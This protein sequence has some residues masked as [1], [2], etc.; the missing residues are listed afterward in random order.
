[1]STYCIYRMS[2]LTGQKDR[3]FRG[4]R[5]NGRPIFA[6]DSE[7]N[8]YQLPTMKFRNRQEA[9]RFVEAIRVNHNL[10]QGGAIA[11]VCLGVFFTN[12]KK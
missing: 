10:N 6:R 3:P 2:S 5:T 9:A 1:M 4:F 8:R 11:N 7:I 12:P